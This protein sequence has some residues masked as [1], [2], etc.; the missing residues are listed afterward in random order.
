M[1]NKNRMITGKTDITQL[2]VEAILNAANVSLPGG[3]GVKKASHR[4]HRGH[5]EGIKVG[6]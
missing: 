4:G 2:S 3:G 5:R 6:R 1:L